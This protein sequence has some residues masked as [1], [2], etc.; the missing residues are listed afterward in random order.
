[1][2]FQRASQVDVFESKKERIKIPESGS[3][4]LLHF[5]WKT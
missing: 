1:M 5:Y 2:T 3:G 4:Y